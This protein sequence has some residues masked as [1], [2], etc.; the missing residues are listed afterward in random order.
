[1]R[2]ALRTVD[3]RSRRPACLWPIPAAVYWFGVSEDGSQ[4][5]SGEGIQT[6]AYSGGTYTDPGTVRGCGVRYRSMADG[7]EVAPAVVTVDACAVGAIGHGTV[8]PVPPRGSS[9]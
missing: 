4:L 1:N 7:T 6:T 5:V 8:G 2:T 9:P 3:L